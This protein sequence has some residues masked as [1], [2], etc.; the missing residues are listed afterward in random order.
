MILSEIQSI[1]KRNVTFIAGT[2]SFIKVIFLICYFII[3]STLLLLF[4]SHY[5][6]DLNNWHWLLIFMVGSLF[7]CLPFKLGASNADINICIDANSVYI[8]LAYPLNGK[9][10]RVLTS[11]IKKFKQCFIE[12]NYRGVAIIVS[13]ESL[14][15][16]LQYDL[17]YMVCRDD[18]NTISISIPAGMSTYSQIYK[19]L[20]LCG[21]RTD[22]IW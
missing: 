4:F 15:P 6:S 16:V 11:Q 17:A 22:K 12:N 9:Y 10:L 7:I 13:E 20:K 3:G 1:D 2:S 21:V 18:K 8:K 14:E 5:E 19:N